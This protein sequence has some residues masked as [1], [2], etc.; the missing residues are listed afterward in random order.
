M[1]RATILGFADQDQP[2]LVQPFRPEFFAALGDVWGEWSSAMAQDF[3]EYGYLICAVDTST[4]TATDAYLAASPEPPSALRRL[5]AEG[6]DEVA[7]ALRNQARDR[8]AR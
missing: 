8:E 6:R 1:F 2:E 5:L 3:V 4:I 7:R